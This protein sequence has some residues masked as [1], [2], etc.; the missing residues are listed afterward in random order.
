VTWARAGGQILVDQLVRHGADRV[1][2]VPGESYL[3][4]LDALRDAPVAVTVCRQEGGAAMMAEADG[5]LTGRPGICFATRG[6][7]ATNASPGV[8]VADQD[9]TPMILFVG[10]P[11]RRFTGRTAFQEL[12]CRSAFSAITKWAAQADDPASIPEIVARAFQVAA[13]GRPGPVVVSLPEDVLTARAETADAGFRELAESYPSEDQIREVTA[14]LAHARLPV[15]ILGGSRWSAAAV[16]RFTAFAEAYDLPVAVTFRRQMLFSADHRNYVGELGV[17]PNPALVDLVKRADV[18]LL[19]GDQLSQVPS[20][21]YTLLDTPDP[22]R[23]IHV[24]PDPG[25]LGRLHHPHLAISASPEAFCARLGGLRPVQP[26]A[27]AGA[28][29]AAR[30]AYLDW[31]DPA[32]AVTPGALQL[33]AVMGFLQ[34]RLPADAIVCN[35]AGNYA[36]WVHRYL[37]FRGYGTQLAPTSGSMG[38]GVPAAVAAIQRYPDRKVIAFAGDGCFLMNGQEFAT[39]V[40]YDLPVIVIV[41]DNGMYGTIRMHQ[42]RQYPGRVSGTD[43]RN[44]DFVGYGRAFGGHGERVE[45]TDEFAPAFERAAAA[46]KPAIIHCIIEPNAIAP[47]ATISGIRRE[48]LALRSPRCQALTG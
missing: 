47:S 37:R 39:A 8:Y 48:A 29:R 28:A 21:D 45:R 12:D 22:P 2:C 41:I 16:R 36:A 27:W 42:E 1:F 18:I 38:Y 31:S 34:E 30:A 25:E 17:G 20:Q 24:Y 15:A 13:S 23:L 7:G 35:G 9:A 6:P 32:K 5:K 11:E 10:Q 26:S 19:V 43:L 4:V 46:G 44:P 14:M 3:S 40:Q 33:G